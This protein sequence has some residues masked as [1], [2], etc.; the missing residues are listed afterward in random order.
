MTVDAHHHLID[1]AIRD[2]PWI[3]G[4][5]APL[6]RRWDLADLRVQTA[7]L[8][9]DR[10]IVVQTLADSA[11][12]ED[13][14]SAAAKSGGLIAGVVGWVDL[15][16]A[17]VSDRVDELREAPGGSRLVGVRHQAHDE[18]DPDW[19]ARPDVIRGLRVLAERGLAYDLLVR[20]RELPA[21]LAAVEAVEGLSFVIDH[22]AKPEIA[23]GV[24][25]PWRER[26]AAIAAR[27][28]VTCKVS[29]LVTEAAWAS[30]TV[31]DLQ[32]YVDEL[33]T[34]FGPDRLMWGSDW[35]VCTLAASYA[36]VLSAAR[37][38]LSGL[39][40]VDSA[41]VFAGTATRV[42]HLA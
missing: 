9:V 16:A 10:T 29:G 42:Y 32:P 4:R 13:F 30:W 33:V 11:E 7:D 18:P 26:L 17:D 31:Q 15:T 20:P 21:T 6:R 36:E 1:P 41:A 27:P 12:T 35:P 3:A 37:T 40:P 8:A 38:C 34:L 39:S 24:T 14:L 28:N 19:L 5:Y 2:Y 25:E 22:G 23:A